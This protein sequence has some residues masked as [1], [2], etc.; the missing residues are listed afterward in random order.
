MIIPRANQRD[1]ML[2]EDVVAACAEGRF[3]VWGVGTIQQALEVF[4]DLPAGEAD[5][6]G[7]YP[8]GTLLA[9][10][11]ERADDYWRMSRGLPVEDDDEE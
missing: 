7:R 3:H 2:R 9:L 11:T 10:A 8:E 6:E 4:T 1:L 5:V